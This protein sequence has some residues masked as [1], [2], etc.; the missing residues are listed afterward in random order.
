[1]IPVSSRL[2]RTMKGIKRFEMEGV[3]A[4]L[5]ELSV[6]PALLEGE[7]ILGVYRG[8]GRSKGFIVTSDALI[9]LDEGVPIRCEY[10]KMK[11]SMI[12]AGEKSDASIVQIK[13][14]ND[15]V[16]NVEVD[17]GEG[18]FRDVFSFGRFIGR[19]IEDRS[20]GSV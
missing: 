5:S 1:M 3:G 14:K 15:D 10:E 4:V 7:S 17:G 6:T 12:V 18:R 8:K 16:I 13:L 11:S 20:S 2:H 9:L 19:V